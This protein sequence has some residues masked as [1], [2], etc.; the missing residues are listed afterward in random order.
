[1]KQLIVLLGG[2]FLLFGGC[3]EPNR[4][5][6]GAVKG[7]G[8]K[9]PS[10]LAGTWK[11]RGSKWQVTLAPNGKVI[12]LVNATG[13]SMVIKEGKMFFEEGSTRGEFLHFIFGP[14]FTN[15]NPAT[16]ELGV[17]VTM[18]DFYMQTRKGVLEEDMKYLITGPV[19]EDGN[20]WDAKLFV[21]IT[22]KGG[23]PTEP[24]SA[25]PKI[26]IFDKVRD[27]QSGPPKN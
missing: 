16:R 2:V 19:S 6:S 27:I 15:Y 4:S 20:R 14:C 23:K 12:S 13:S 18:K 17:T 8:K 5:K 25:E 3:Q 10:S 24:N 7:G 11:A 9:F 1:M 21:Y 22:P 26:L